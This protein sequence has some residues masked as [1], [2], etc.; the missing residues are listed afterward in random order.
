[1][2]KHATQ[3]K[4][5]N[6]IICTTHLYL[7]IFK[8]NRNLSLYKWKVPLHKCWVHSQKYTVLKSE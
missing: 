4:K 2:G 1:M 6:D 3:L 5:N 7:N 8:I